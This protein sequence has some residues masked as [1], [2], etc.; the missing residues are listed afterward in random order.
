MLTWSTIPY[1]NNGNPEYKNKADNEDTK[2]IVNDIPN[3]D[4]SDVDE[5]DTDHVENIIV[6]N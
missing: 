2:Q 3:V 1:L 5:F 4:I 6:T